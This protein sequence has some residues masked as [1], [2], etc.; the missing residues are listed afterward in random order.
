MLGKNG[1]PG[2][3]KMLQV[4]RQRTN[5]KIGWVTE[6]GKQARADS[7]RELA[8]WGEAQEMDVH[9]RTQSDWAVLA[10]G[11]PRGAV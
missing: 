2:R 4:A 7:M 5:E 10:I 8:E 3:S 1:E 11:G 9:C 6:R